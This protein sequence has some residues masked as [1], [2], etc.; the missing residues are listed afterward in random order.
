MSRYSKGD[1]LCHQKGI[2]VAVSGILVLLV[3]LLLRIHYSLYQY[4]ISATILGRAV[5]W[6]EARNGLAKTK[7]Y[8][9]L[10]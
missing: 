1:T 5:E 2:N 4:P 9:N 6:F 7:L 10:F 8:E 3:Y